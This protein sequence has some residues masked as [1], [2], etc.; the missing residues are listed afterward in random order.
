MTGRPEANINWKEVEELLIC[1]CPGS[2]IADQFG[3][4]QNTLYDRCLKDHGINFSEFSSRSQAKGNGLL[5]K[6][7]FLKALGK[8]QEGDNTLLIWLGKVRL[9]QKEE[10]NVSQE[11]VQ[12][13]NSVIEFITER[14]KKR[15]ESLDSSE[16]NNP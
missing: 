14:Q 8:T 12:R 4:H 5:R 6:V 7:Q 16:E 10:Q 2:E 3:I 9:K 13:L 15:Q 1:G 11:E